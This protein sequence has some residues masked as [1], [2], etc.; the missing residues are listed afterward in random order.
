MKWILLTLAVVSV[1][2]AG[3]NFVRAPDSVLF[4]KV[5][6]ATTEYGHLLVLFPLG[7]A[8]LAGIST[9]GLW[10]AGLL[11]LCGLA[12]AGLLRPVYTAWRLAADLPRQLT[13]A[14]GTTAGTP[15]AFS[16]GRL[17]VH[18]L[19]AAP[20]ATEVYSRADG[21]E[22]SLD[23]YRALRPE[24]APCLIVV[25]GGG[26]D[27]GDSSQLAGW[28]RRWAV[29]GYAVAAVNYR[30]APRHLWPAPRD[31][32]RAAL[33]W[34]K[35]NAARLGIDPRRLVLLGRSAGGQIAAAAGYG[36][37]DAGI[38]G[39]ISLYAPQDMPFAWSVSREDDALNSIALL[40][41]YF[42]GAPDTPARRALY[43]SAS[44]QLMVGPGTPPTLLIHGEP[45]TLV[46]HRHSRRLA[47][48]LREAGVP[49]F[50]LELPWATHGFDHNP[51]GPGGQLADY[52]IARF[53]AAVTSVRHRWE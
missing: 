52:A 29:R 40:R 50:L 9:H 38:V 15:P 22:L 16:L 8:A 2:S 36:A 21:R 45:D 34:L 30:L 28:N 23:F 19:P 47:A 3:L 5:A 24:P 1:L 6:V 33:A 46:W 43:E 27:S 32:L 12:A 17:Y 11:V 10:R 51:D 49:H 42:G 35:Q 26:W 31:D 41:R 44:A 14:M 37:H 13:A 53:L 39:V 4:W 7:L 25:H 48:R 18:P 20:M